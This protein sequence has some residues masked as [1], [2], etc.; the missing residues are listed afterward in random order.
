MY[1]ENCEGRNAEI[2]GRSA[3]SSAEWLNRDPLGAAFWNS[4]SLPWTGGE[5]GWGESGTS[6]GKGGSTSGHRNGNPRVQGVSSSH[7][8]RD[9][10]RGVTEPRKPEK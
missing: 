1:R 6:M 9:L 10:P 8:S 4:S 2:S 3:R 7:P 5:M